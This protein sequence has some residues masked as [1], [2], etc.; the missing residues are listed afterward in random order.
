MNSG[1]IPLQ[2]KLHELEQEVQFLKKTN[3]GIRRTL[4]ELAML[5]AMLK[6][7]PTLKSVDD[8]I[9]QFVHI[10]KN[11]FP[12]KAHVYYTLNYDDLSLHPVGDVLNQHALLHHHFEINESILIWVLNENQI[13][14]VEPINDSLKDSVS[15]V[16]IPLN[17]TSRMIGVMVFEI[18]AKGDVILTATTREIL[19]IAASQASTSIENIFLY[20]DMQQKNKNLHKIK[21]FTSN[22]LESLVNGIIAFNTEREIIHINHNASVMFGILDQ[23]PVGKHYKTVLPVAF[24]EILHI[25]F[26]QTEKDGYVMDYQ[27]EFELP[28]GVVIPYGISTSILRDENSE[29]LGITLV[30]RDMTASRELERLRSLDQLKNDFVSTVSHELRSPLATIRAYIDTLVNRVDKDDIEARDMFLKTIEE[31]ANRLTTLVE[32]MLDIASIESG[33]IQLELSRMPV[34]TI[35]L[36]VAKLCQMQSQIHTVKTEI[37]DNLPMLSLDKDRM[38]QVLYNLVNNAIK[39]S[40]DGGDVTVRAYEKDSAL[41]ISVVDQGMGLKPEDLKQVFNKFFRVNSMK[42]SNIGGTGLGLAIV[43]KLVELHHGKLDVSSKYGEGSTFSVIL[44][45]G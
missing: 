24:A 14:T 32:N 40:P 13:V 23:N 5:Q 12:Y 27:M 10:I 39:Y 4:E 33:K 43:K 11:Y 30:A 3:H 20:E 45:I 9:D 29:S 18:M 42:T 26:E 37:A 8:V 19:E 41:H 35:I 22:I 17:T 36:S 2:T 6:G 21:A 15:L 38:I 31:E 28:G 25:L 7:I 34:D 1:E 16:A 44:P